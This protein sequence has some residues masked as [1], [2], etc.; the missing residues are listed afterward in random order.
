MIDLKPDNKYTILGMSE[1][2]FPFHIHVRHKVLKRMENGYAQYKDAYAWAFVKKGC[3]RAAGF[4]IYGDRTF[5]VFE[6]WIDLDTHM[7]K[8]GSNESYFS[9]SD[10]YITDALKS[11]GSKAIEISVKTLK[12]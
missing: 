3:R 1:F 11:T 10:K 7:F 9:F 5:Y 4:Y 2:G 12:E 6:G 8:K